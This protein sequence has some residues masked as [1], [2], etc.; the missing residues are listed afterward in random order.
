M[1]NQ[2]VMKMQLIVQ[3]NLKI[4]DALEKIYVPTSKEK[5]KA[6]ELYVKKL[7]K[8]VHFLAGNNLPVK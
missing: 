4:K 7:T 6:N 2:R 1:T 5:S 8:I 3:A